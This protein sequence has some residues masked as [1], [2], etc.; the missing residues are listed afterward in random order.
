M[1]KKLSNELPDPFDNAA[2][3][4]FQN[5]P[6][7]VI[8]I[9]TGYESPII[10]PLRTKLAIR[11]KRE[12]DVLAKI[13]IPSARNPKR[14]IWVLVHIEFQTE[15]TLIMP[16]RMAEYIARVL[17]VYQLPV[18]SVVI[19]LREKKIRKPDPGFFQQTYPTRFLAEY[20]VIRL[21]ELDGQSYLDNPTPGNLPFIPLMKP[22]EGDSREA[23]LER[24]VE[25]GQERIPPEQRADLFYSMNV[26]SGLIIKNQQTIDLII[27]E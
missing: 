5:R 7:D 4:V 9:A 14:L 27:P 12:V 17:R 16:Y 3:I 11:R 10:Q 15:P 1:R 2:K 22:A 13:K 18:L 24:C 26:L 20:K 21:W 6:P 23:W 8:K 25:V 19:Y